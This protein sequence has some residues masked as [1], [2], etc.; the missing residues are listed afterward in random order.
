[1]DALAKKRT[2]RRLH[3]HLGYWADRAD[4][5]FLAALLQEA[6]RQISDDLGLDAA[7]VSDALKQCRAG[8]PNELAGKIQSRVDCSFK[9]TSANR[10]SVTLSISFLKDGKPWLTQVR[11]ETSWDELPGEIRAE[12]IEKNPAELCYILC[13]FPGCRATQ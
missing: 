1:V 9:K 4:D 6:A 3:Q 13:D 11:Q 12:F 8:L 2:G 7:E 10:I 5:S